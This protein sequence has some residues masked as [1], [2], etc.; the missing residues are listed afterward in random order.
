ME[1]SNTEYTLATTADGIELYIHQNNGEVFAS[2]RMLGRLVGKEHST[3]G[4]WATGA[5]I[6]PKVVEVPTPKGIRTGALYDED[7]IHEAFAKWKPELLIKCTKAG[8]RVYLH[9]LAGYT[10]EVRQQPY[11]ADD[12]IIS[13]LQQIMQVRQ[14]QLDQERRIAALEHERAAAL[15]ELRALPAPSAE[16]PEETT[17]MKVRRIVNDYSA[18]TGIAQGEVWRRLYQE[19]Y[20][21]YRSRVMAQGKESKLQAFVRL[22]RIDELYA[23]ATDLF[24]SGVVG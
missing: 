2:Q 16:V 18:A 22:G 24:L 23:L 12:P 9:G 8:I 6:T 11:P 20:Y 3:I 10:Y 21:R 13:S 14:Q 19:H 17:D 15:E 4:R 5:Q 1:N 7:A